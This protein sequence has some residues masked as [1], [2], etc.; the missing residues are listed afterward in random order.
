MVDTLRS[1]ESEQ[2][3]VLCIML[4]L[5]IQEIKASHAIMV[6]IL[7]YA[8]SILSVFSA[9]TQMHTDTFLSITLL[10]FNGFLIQ[11]KF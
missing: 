11:K 8:M 10:I 7:C 9:V 6:Q 4:I 5:S 3:I 1:K 2:C